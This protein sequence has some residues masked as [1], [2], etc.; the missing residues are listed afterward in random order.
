M[1]YNLDLANLDI[2]AFTY[3]GL[4]KISLDL[5]TPTS[6]ITLNSKELKI[7]E[8]TVKVEDSNGKYIYTS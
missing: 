5:K 2:K 8:G 3:D 4:V 7:G 1:H 6:F